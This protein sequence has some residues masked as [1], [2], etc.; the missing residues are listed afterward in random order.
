[1]CPMLQHVAELDFKERSYL[2][3]RFFREF[4]GLL[5]KPGYEEVGVSRPSRSSSMSSSSQEG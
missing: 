2:L 1:M 5:P 3:R 4:H